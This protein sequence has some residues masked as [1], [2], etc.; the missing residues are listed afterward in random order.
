MELACPPAQAAQRRGLVR[1]FPEEGLWW[2]SAGAGA[3]WA[4][5]WFLIG[6]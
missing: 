5:R 4:D 2:R 1:G 3:F 6:W